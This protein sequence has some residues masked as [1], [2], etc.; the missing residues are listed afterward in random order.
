MIGHS[1][2]SPPWSAGGS[3]PLSQN[4]M[5]VLPEAGCRSKVR[6]DAAFAHPG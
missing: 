6:F 1:G 4:R 5:E 3:T 2:R